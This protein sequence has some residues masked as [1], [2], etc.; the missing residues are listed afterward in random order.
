MFSNFRQESWVS[1]HQAYRTSN[2]GGMEG[3]CNA[4]QA[5]NPVAPAARKI[6]PS[7]CDGCQFATLVVDDEFDKA[8]I[9]EDHK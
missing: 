6:C 2:Y 8:R 7:A 9:Q 4:L 1:H 3:A 5:A